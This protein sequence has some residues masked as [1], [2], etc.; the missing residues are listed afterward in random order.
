MALVARAATTA[1]RHAFSA[2]TARIVGN[3]A[4]AQLAVLPKRLASSS[5]S[6]PLS[7]HLTIYRF[8]INMITSTIFRG[9]GIAMTGGT[10]TP[11]GALYC[12]GALCG[13]SGPAAPRRRNA[14]RAL[15]RLPPPP[16][17]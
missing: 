1:A 15:R 16:I 9:T 4:G 10:C 17:P 5:S 7:P 3:A 8:G 6:R 11:W 12:G 13:G 14:G 2:P